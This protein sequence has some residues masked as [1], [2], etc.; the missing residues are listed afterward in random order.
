MILW[1]ARET[2]EAIHEQQLI[3]HG[4]RPG[5]NG[6][7]GKLLAILASP[8]NIEA[9]RDSYDLADLA[10]CYAHRIATGHPFLEGNKRTSWVVTRTFCRLN[11]HDVST[12]RTER[13]DT[14][15]QL[16]DGKISEATVSAWIRA[17]LFRRLP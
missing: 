2:V 5:F 8:R 11:G 15:E 6:D 10:G 4:G 3:A 17:R 13:L 14:W 1:L 16:G 12:E 7:E 9:Y